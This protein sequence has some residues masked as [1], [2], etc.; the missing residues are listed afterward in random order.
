MS[1][2]IISRCITFSVPVFRIFPSPRH[3]R[4]ADAIS[5][6]G[7]ALRNIADLCIFRLMQRPAAHLRFR[8]V[9]GHFFPFSSSATLALSLSISQQIASSAA[10][11]CSAGVAR[12]PTHSR[13]TAHTESHVLIAAAVPIV[14]PPHPCTFG[15]ASQRL[16]RRCS[17]GSCRLPWGRQTPWI[18]TKSAARRP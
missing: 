17:S 8:F 12:G 9:L 5:D 13:T 18:Q 11:C 15:D 10:L 14:R 1:I 6:A 7:P 2:H 4:R 16:A 3:A